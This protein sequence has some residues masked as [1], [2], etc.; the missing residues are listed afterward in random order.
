MSRLEN[1]GLSTIECLVALVVLMAGLTGA[2][3]AGLLAIRAARE[4]EIRM[5]VALHARDRLEW[6]A[7]RATDLRGCQALTDSS[8]GHLDEV[9]ERWTL[10]PAPRG[11]WVTLAL[12]WAGGFRRH[13]DTIRTRLLCGG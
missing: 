4:A 12:D 2:T 8:A 11:W 5:R 3:A 7:G 1:S 9:T 13:S 6:L 10:A